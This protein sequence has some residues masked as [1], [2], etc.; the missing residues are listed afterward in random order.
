[1]RWNEI[2]ERLRLLYNNVGI[3]FSEGSSAS[4]ASKA[5][6][7]AFELMEELTIELEKINTQSK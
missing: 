7:K 1:M 3:A 5:D 2:D 6:Q 4:S